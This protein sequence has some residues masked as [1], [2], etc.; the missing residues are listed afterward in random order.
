M[1]I[2]QLILDKPF[3]HDKNISTGDPDGN[4]VHNGQN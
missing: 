3:S 2:F 4:F 1:Y